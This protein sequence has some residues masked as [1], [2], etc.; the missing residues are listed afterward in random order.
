MI[1]AM[2]SNSSSAA[3]ASTDANGAP[4][5]APEWT[6][7]DEDE[8]EEKKQSQGFIANRLYSVVLCQDIGG[9]ELVLLHNPWSDSCWSGEW[10][11]TS[12]DWETYPEILGHIQEDKSILW[13]LENPNGYFWMTFKNFNKYFNSVYFCKLFP[14]QQF[15]YYCIK[16]EWKDKSAGGPMTTLRNAEEV[17]KKAEES[18]IHAIQKVTN[19]C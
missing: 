6:N 16:G 18:R 7:D 14:S 3:N 13:S 17:A 11:D 10:S 12:S 5:A 15:T 19:S 9:F 2:P 1:L 8:F 4:V